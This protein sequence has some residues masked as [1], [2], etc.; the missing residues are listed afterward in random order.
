LA[1]QQGEDAQLATRRTS[2]QHREKI[3]EAVRSAEDEIG[4]GRGA[5]RALGNAMKALTRTAGQAGGKL[6][7]V[8]AGLDAAVVTLAEAR[9]LLQAT[10]ADLNSEAEGNLETIEE[11]LF[12]L[13][14][15]GRKYQVDVDGLAGLAAQLSTRLSLIEDQGGR[16]GK[17]A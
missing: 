8:I 5:E 1:P 13:R 9:R 7:P 6:D 16:L 14:A 2:L 17:L 10:V 15:A 4:G 12:A 3:L 11:R